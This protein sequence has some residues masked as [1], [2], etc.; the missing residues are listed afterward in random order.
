MNGIFNVNYDAC[1]VVNGYMAD[2]IW[3][4][5]FEMPLN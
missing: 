4:Y 2:V 5:C 3:T 1:Y